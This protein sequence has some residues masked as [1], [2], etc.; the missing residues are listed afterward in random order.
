MRASG[1]EKVLDDYRVRMREEREKME[2]MSADDFRRRID[3]FLLPIGEEV[4]RFLIDLAVGL[5]AKRIVELG[6]SYG[7]ST[8]YLAEAARRT[9]GS[10]ATYDL[11]ADK[12]A[13][14]RARLA[15]AGLADFIDWRCGD[16]LE[17]LQ[18]EKA[19][20]DLVLLDIWKDLYVPCFDLIYPK[21]G[22]GAVVIADN[23]MRPESARPDAERYRAAVRATG[24]MEA[25]T[26]PIGNGIDIARR[27]S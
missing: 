24:N 12:Q 11:S 1:F 16:A 23:M 7:F 26:L 17:L 4:A 14:A 22:P 19:P 5:N 6:T 3:E 8:L 13:Y 18:L 20:V 2:G 10:V 27:M 15:E 25:V 9:G 21:L